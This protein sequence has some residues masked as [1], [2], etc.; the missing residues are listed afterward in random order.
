MLFGV[1]AD[2]GCLILSGI[3]A[4]QAD[5]VEAVYRA[6]GLPRARRLYDGEWVALIWGWDPA[7][8][9]I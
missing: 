2:G 5:R 4:E 7:E 1:L 3:L 9:G 8:P 6:Q